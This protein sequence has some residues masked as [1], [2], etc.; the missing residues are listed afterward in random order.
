MLSQTLRVIVSTTL[1]I[2]FVASV[3]V[4]AAMA[5]AEDNLRLVT[6]VMKG[7]RDQVRTL[8]KQKV[9]VNVAA[10]DGMTALHWA[11]YKNDIEIARMLVQASANVKA[12]TRREAVV[13]LYM[14][15]TNGNP[16]IIDLLVKAGADVN[17]AT[18]SGAMPL[19]QAAAS[20]DVEAVKKLLDYG[21]DIN[22]KDNVRDQTALMFAA[23]K[24]RDSVIQ[25]LASRGAALER[26]TR[27]TV[28]EQYF[29]EAGIFSV[30][31]GEEPPSNT[32][33]PNMV[34]YEGPRPK[35]MGGMTALLYAAR[36]GH[37]EAVRALVA[38]GA[39][40]N[41]PIPSD[42]TTPMIE[43]IINGHYDA[44][45][46]LLEHG[47]NPNLATVD[48]L[49]ALY[50]TIDNE[51]APVAWSATS[52]TWSDG[53]EQQH[54]SH[55]DLMKE[56]LEYGANPN[57][58]LTNVL[59]FRPPHHNLM[60]V[61]TTGST[62]FWR[63]AQ[64]TDIAAMKLLVDRG[65]NPRVASAQKDT[66][67]HMAAGIGWAGNFSINAPDPNGFMA[68]AR[69]LV[70]EVGIDVNAVD[71][72]GYTS[73]MGAAYRGD[74]EMA[75]YL[76]SKG[77]KL[78]HRNNQGWSATDMAMAPNLQAGVGVAHPETAGLLIKLGAPQ[79]IKVDDEEI[80]GIIKR[81]VSLK[82]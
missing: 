4:A 65:A 5:G 36:E 15:A 2:V 75:Q 31:Q 61:K 47:G 34:D 53:T 78:D 56:L 16:D 79:A 77:A 32:P 13:P 9:N 22:A 21:A 11:V 27:V 72:L 81:K 68:A 49:E 1:L 76:V 62:A 80:L 39:D 50:A 59:W 73:V 64:A 14:A 41:K 20:G 63:A 26:T 17:G 69:Y 57:V 29:T 8:L 82:P 46:Y 48:G 25:L 24:N 44:A 67:L 54:T 42:K 23:A 37:M 30:K 7:D 19:M 43:A 12:A 38:A 3:G 60:W 40:V 45:K 70:E 35:T 10:G 71:E 74:S 55:L 51:Y 66:P 6:A 58:A 18:S 52:H 28:I 33:T